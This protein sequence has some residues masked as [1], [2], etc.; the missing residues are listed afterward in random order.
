[1]NNRV[2][3]FVAACAAIAVPAAAA[4]QSRLVTGPQVHR[5]HQGGGD[6]FDQR[7]RRSGRGD[8]VYVSDVNGGEWALYNNRSWEPQSYNDWWHDR[9]DRAFPRW[10][11]QSREN[12]MCD[13]NRMWWSG[14]G[15]RC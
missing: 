12:A 3:G 13:E 9:P 7:D 14:A 11:Q 6:R 4:A 8:A 10:V 5:G 15:W 2:F 1:M